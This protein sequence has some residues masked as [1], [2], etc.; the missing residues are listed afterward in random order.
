MLGE[1][2]GRIVR[3]SCGGGGLLGIFRMW[4]RHGGFKLIGRGGGCNVESI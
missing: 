2:V 1:L 3:M 4:I